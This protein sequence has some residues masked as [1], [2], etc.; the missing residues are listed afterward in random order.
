MSTNS[1]N[2]KT[3]EIQREKMEIWRDIEGYEGLYQVSNEGNGK[4]LERTIIYKDGRKKLIKEHQL[5]KNPIPS[6]HLY[7]VL[8]KNGKVE[9]IQVH[10][11]VAQAFIPNLDPT[12]YT[13]VHHINEDPTDNRVENLVWMTKQEHQALHMPEALGKTVYQYTLND[14]LVKIWN[15]ASDAARELGFSQGGISERCRGGAYRNG[16]W[17]NSYTYKGF[18]W[19][20]ER[21]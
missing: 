6:G 4:S 9:H 1:K 5:E 14:K 7:F 8:S 20:Y 18:K 3:P 10:K 13:I 16:K 17:F 15:T 11:V 21:L 12:R 2:Y 19:S